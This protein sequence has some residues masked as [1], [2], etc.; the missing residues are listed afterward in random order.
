MK[1]ISGLL[2]LLGFI[3]LIIGVIEPQSDILMAT[4]IIVI[5]MGIY[6]E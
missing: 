2:M 4:G 1:K 5:A 6:K 3:W